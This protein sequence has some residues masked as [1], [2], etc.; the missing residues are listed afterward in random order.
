VSELPPI[1]V[2]VTEHRLHRL[3]CPQCAQETRAEIPPEVPR[4][5]FGPRLHAT[6]ATLAVRNRVSRRD[7]VE[8]IRELFGCRLATGTIDA[9]VQGAG[10]ALK[11]PHARL[12]DDVRSAPAVNID[13]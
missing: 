13:E 10:E 12:R 6:V 4:S 9:I 5:A 8:L 1:A 3:R 11:E 7:T 2:R